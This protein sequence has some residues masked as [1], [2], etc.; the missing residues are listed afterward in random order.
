VRKGDGTNDNLN[1]YRKSYKS[2]LRD[3]FSLLFF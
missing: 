1:T 2:F 3:K